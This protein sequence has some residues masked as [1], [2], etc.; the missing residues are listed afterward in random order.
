MPRKIKDFKLG[1][2]IYFVDMEND[3]TWWIKNKPY[4][5]I[6]IVKEFDGKEFC[7]VRNEEGDRKKF[8]NTSYSIFLHEY[9][10]RVK[11]NRLERKE[12]LRRI[13]RRKNEI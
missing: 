5:V 4:P 12:K 9:S 7:W 3:Q 13:K 8:E 2:T 10:N 1:D 6:E 11:C